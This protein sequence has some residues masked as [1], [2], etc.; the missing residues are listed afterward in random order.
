MAMDKERTS[1]STSHG[2]ALPPIPET[3]SIPLP[4]RERRNTRAQ[5][6]EACGLFSRH[7]RETRPPRSARGET[8][9]GRPEPSALERQR[10]KEL[11][12]S[13]VTAF[14]ING[15]LIWLLVFTVIENSKPAP[16]T[17][18]DVSTQQEKDMSSKVSGSPPPTPLTQEKA[19][20]GAAAPSTSLITTTAIQEFT[21]DSSLHT[22]LTPSLAS[23][24]VLN[25]SMGASIQSSAFADAK[26]QKKKAIRKFIEG[27]SGNGSNGRGVFTIGEDKLRGLISTGQFGDGSGLLLLTDI[28]GSMREIG[29]VVDS[30]VKRTFP[31]SKSSQIPGCSFKYKHDP[32][33]EEVVRLTRRSDFTDIVFVCDLQDG[34]GNSAIQTLR[35]ALIRPER[36]IR[37]HVI[38]FD[39]RAG[40]SLNSLIMD[41]G[42]ALTRVSRTGP[43]K[44]L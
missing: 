34:E 38:S 14:A 17:F 13:L 3:I 19:A 23:I 16:G 18:F 36:T 1:E 40:P 20:S 29:E 27:N 9:A 12:Q 11:A 32:V 25:P 39:N 7:R 10:K 41:S 24:D 43:P 8:K 6:S 30:Y 2:P 28:S 44:S 35:R 26:S 33:V 31:K 5:K 22:E 37:F 21:I 15:A 42:G 4:P